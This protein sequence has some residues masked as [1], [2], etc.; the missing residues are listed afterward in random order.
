MSEWRK[1]SSSIGNGACLEVGAWRKSS[2]SAAGNC[3]EAASW[4]KS[5]R[6]THNGAC[7]EV[8]AGAGVVGVRDTKNNGSGPVLEFSTGAWKDFISGLKG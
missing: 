6:S 7:A 5:Q 8:G 1:S 2:R 4:R 3:V